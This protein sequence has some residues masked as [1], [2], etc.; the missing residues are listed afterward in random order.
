MAHAQSTGTRTRPG[1]G[2]PAVP[3]PGGPGLPVPP[4]LPAP[5]VGPQADPG[6]A[7]RARARRDAWTTP[8][9][10]WLALLGTV[11]SILLLAGVAAANVQSESTAARQTN[12]AVEYRAVN[13]QEL[14]Y[15]LS[16]ADAAAATG[17]LDSPAPSARFT[18]RYQSDI[19]QADDALAE[20]SGDVV[21]DDSASAQLQKVDEQLSEYTGLIGTAQANN[22][23]GYPVGGAYLREASNLL[24][25]TMLPEV[26]SVLA[27]EISARSASAS[28]SGGFPLWTVLAALLMLIV[29]VR[30]WRLLAS[31]TRRSVNA[32][33]AAG[34]V[35]S[36]LL[37]GWV[38]ATSTEAAHHMSAASNDFLQVAA[39]QQ[40]RGDAAQ[41]SA[42]EASS[43]VSEG[44]D[45]G[46][47]AAL[48]QHAVTDLHDEIGPA[49]GYANPADSSDTALAGKI[50]SDV[51]TIQKDAN[52]SDYV[53]ATTAMVGS[54][55]T[56][57]GGAQV[58]LDAMASALAG[59]EQSA[60]AAYERD[61]SKAVHDY[62]GGPWP[63]L[64]LGLLAAVAAAYGVT[65]RIAEYR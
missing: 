2:S 33:L 24:E 25:K 17:I 54:S 42:D 28:D 12:G 6:L 45:G 36:V 61:S 11:L 53:D 21:G 14:Y 48:G 51:T 41:I 56:T 37:F 23:L 13:V 34:L 5:V 46:A 20:S 47:A 31:R 39:A 55:A 59:N 27:G 49:T 43:V 4:G 62:P 58:D 35:L 18:T 9:R 60:Q 52:A 7:A 29:G 22:R 19:T 30:T 44:A 8:T 64:A 3:G 15:A 32:G 63:I 16:D 38:A 10:L 57:S 40:G 1:A 26:Q 65:R 50:S